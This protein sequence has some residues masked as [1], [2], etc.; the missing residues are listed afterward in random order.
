MLDTD[1]PPDE[2]QQLR[3]GIFSSHFREFFYDPSKGGVVGFRRMSDAHGKIRAGSARQ[4]DLLLRAHLPALVIGWNH[5]P[6]AGLMSAALPEPA[7]T[8]SYV[9]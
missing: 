6:S 1:V 3:V 4:A 2:M 8:V 7:D 5:G 9:A